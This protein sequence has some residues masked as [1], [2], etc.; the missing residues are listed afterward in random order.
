ML[1]PRDLAPVPVHQPQI[2]SP[3]GGLV[4]IDFQD[5]G[6]GIPAE[7]LERVFEPGFSTTPGSPGLG[8]SVSKKVVEQHGGEI[9]VRSQPHNGPTFRSLRTKAAPISP[10]PKPTLPTRRR[11]SELP[12]ATVNRLSPVW[13][14]LRPTPPR[15]GPTCRVTRYSSRTK[16]FPSRSSIR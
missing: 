10:A 11:P 8:L 14:K 6:R 16:K 4:R 13:P 5:Q 3:T 2:G 9:Q 7:L 12:S 1:A 15:L